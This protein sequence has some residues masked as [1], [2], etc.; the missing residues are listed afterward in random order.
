MIVQVILGVLR[1]LLPAIFQASGDTV[2][3]AGGS[4]QVKRSLKAKIRTIWVLAAV[5]CL[6]M[7]GCFTRTVYVPEGEP[8]RL[9][10]T[11]KDA[12]VWIKT[13]SGKTVKGKIDLKEGW[14]ALSLPGK[15]E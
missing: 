5:C 15:D 6:F 11:I 4:A 13:E 8:V 3:D 14:Y 7:S 12:P 9:R 2:E 10:A 1:I